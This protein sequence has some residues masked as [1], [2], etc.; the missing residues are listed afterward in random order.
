MLSTA[1]AVIVTTSY[2]PPFGAGPLNDYGWKA[3]INYELPAECFS[4]PGA[5]INLFG[6]ILGCEAPRVA[7]FK[8]LS[9][10]VGIYRLDT[11]NFLVDVLTFDPTS[12]PLL[13]VGI[14]PPDV[15][16]QVYAWRPSNTVRGTADFNDDIDFRLLLQ[17]PVAEVE[18]RQC[19]PGSR[20]SAW[21]TGPAPV[22]TASIRYA[23]GTT[24]SQVFGQTELR[25]G[26]VPEPGTMALVLLA[27][28][29]G[30]TVVRRRR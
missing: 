21:T 16:T 7:D 20:C 8:V 9:A 28:G 14:T 13:A 4:T 6:L 19:V 1:S 24:F 29:A 18:Y 17:G 3:T 5:K 2:D 11:P 25:V 12:L 27:L 26:A 15:V 22:R 23:D 30:V 10:Q